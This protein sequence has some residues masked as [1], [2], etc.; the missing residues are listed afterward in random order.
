MVSV[1]NVVD[2]SGYSQ[3]VP[4]DPVNESGRVTPGQSRKAQPI[5]ANTKRNT[6]PFAT[7]PPFSAIPLCQVMRDS[8][9]QKA[10]L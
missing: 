4:T 10:N 2:V 1:A 7:G 6:C 3:V 9:T 5:A 8:T